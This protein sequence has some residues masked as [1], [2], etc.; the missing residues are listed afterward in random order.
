MRVTGDGV[1]TRAGWWGDYGRMVEVRHIN[2]IRTRYAHLRSIS[3]RQ[4]QR[5]AQGETVGQVGAT[6]LATASHL[7]YEFL[8]YGRHVDPGSVD[9]PRAEPIPEE[10]NARFGLR[11]AALR[12]LLA[13][14]PMPVASAVA[15]APTESRATID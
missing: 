5:V 4:G 11:R 2:G 15:R 8:R 13:R 7:H 9:M 1:V 14:A 3:V 10:E 12:R 6:G